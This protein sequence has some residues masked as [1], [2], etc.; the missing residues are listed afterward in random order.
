MLCITTSTCVNLSLIIIYYLWNVLFWGS[1]LLNPFGSIDSHGTDHFLH[2]REQIAL[3]GQLKLLLGVGRLVRC[4]NNDTLQKDTWHLKWRN[5]H[6]IEKKKY[7]INIKIYTI[8]IYIYITKKYKSITNHKNPW[9]NAMISCYFPITTYGNLWVYMEFCPEKS[10]TQQ[11]AI[12]KT[13][14]ARPR[15]AGWLLRLR[16]RCCNQRGLQP[17]GFDQSIWGIAIQNRDVT[18]NN[19]DRIWYNGRF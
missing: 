10:M 4:G 15:V 12:E 3:G 1:L 2:L 6:I 17:P 11:P 13:S 7:A 5:T 16:L 9:K 19:G 18:G 14:E 8:I